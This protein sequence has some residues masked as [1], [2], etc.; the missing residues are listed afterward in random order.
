MLIPQELQLSRK[1]LW[2]AAQFENLGQSEKLFRL[3]KKV[4]K[5]CFHALHVL[6]PFVYQC[7]GVKGD[8]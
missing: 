8:R 4:D 7:F 2:G 5:S 3:Q 6:N 1:G